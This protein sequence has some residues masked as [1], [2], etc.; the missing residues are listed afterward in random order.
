MSRPKVVLI[1]WSAADW[2]LLHPLLDSDAMPNLAGLLARGVLGTLAAPMPLVDSL[3]WTSLATGVRA[4]EHGILG[5][6]AAGAS[7]SLRDRNRP[8]FWDFL[9]AR[10]LA[11]HLVNWPL[12]EPAEPSGGVTVA[13]TF[14]EL[15]PKLRHAEASQLVQPSDLAG[16]LARF[17]VEPGEVDDTTLR[18]FVPDLDRVCREE[19]D[20]LRRLKHAVAQVISVQAVTSWLMENRAW[21]VVAVRFKVLADL[22]SWALPLSPPKLDLVGEQEFKLY[23]GV[24]DAAC[25]MLDLLLGPLLQ[26]AIANPTCTGILAWPGCPSRS[27]LRSNASRLTKSIS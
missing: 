22:A 16:T 15:S 18:L 21:D 6:E 4:S 25:R 13:D 17:R 14:F 8:A 26:L 7:L 20:R 1:G 19:D 27:I 9:K 10:N 24:M 2:K 23:R 11:T 5:G 12:T 3:L